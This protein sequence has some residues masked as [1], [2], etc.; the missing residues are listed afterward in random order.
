MFVGK[1]LYAMEPCFF[2]TE[3][4]VEYRAARDPDPDAEG[5]FSTSNPPW[6][7]LGLRTAVQSAAH[8]CSRSNHIASH[9][10][11]PNQCAP[12]PLPPP[13]Q[14]SSLHPPR[15]HLRCW[16]PAG[17]APPSAS[18]PP[19]SRTRTTV[20]ANSESGSVPTRQ[21]GTLQIHVSTHPTP[22]GP[23]DGAGQGWRR[24]RNKGLRQ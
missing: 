13:P 6:R 11:L 2:A 1:A 23:Y 16:S 24:R 9:L 20:F 22:R 19:K 3:E 7:D 21:D 14:S 5:T 8:L 4:D 12:P 15:Y 18:P 17:Q 10:P